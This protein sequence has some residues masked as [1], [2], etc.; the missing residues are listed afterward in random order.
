MNRSITRWIIGACAVTAFAGLSGA[1]AAAPA[2]PT[3]STPA[4]VDQV[5]KR[6]PKVHY[7][8]RT[9]VKKNCPIHWNYPRRGV[10][11]QTWPAGPSTTSKIVGVRYTTVHYAL[12]RDG[13]RQKIHAAPWWGWMA[14]KC[15]VDPVARKFPRVNSPHDLASRRDPEA[16]APHL[17]NR[18]ATGGDNTPKHVDITP[19]P[20]KIKGSVGVGTAGTLRNG[21][22]K[23]ATG[24]VAP[25]WTFKITRANCRRLN[26]QP[27]K[28]SQWVFGYSPDA[29]R[30][31]WVQATHLPACTR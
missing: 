31:G 7:T 23:F 15:L 9:K 19:H 1:A 29:R 12:V 17:A 6:L 26:G 3:G 10:N 11:D 8:N 2:A 4:R 16:Y 22:K 20:R 27:Y 30:W 14:K 28:P 25:G 18:W 24:N 13:Q 21:P 5:Q